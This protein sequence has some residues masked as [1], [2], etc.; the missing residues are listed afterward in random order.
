[1]YFNFLFTHFVYY[2]KILIYKGSDLILKNKEELAKK[3]GISRK[4]LYNYIYELGLSNNLNDSDVIKLEDHVKQKNKNKTISK[5]HL[6]EELENLRLQNAELK[7]VNS[8]LKNGQ[9]VLLQQIEWY[10]NTINNDIAEIKRNMT[11]LLP[12]P[13]ETIPKRKKSLISR[14]LGK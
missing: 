10:K 8:T 4:T 6:Y 5:K 1:M 3:L 2:C 11:L 12:E 14:F 7:K 13:S 9:D